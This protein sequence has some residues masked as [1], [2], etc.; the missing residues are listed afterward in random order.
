MKTV[1]KFAFSLLAA[2]VLFAVFAVFAFSGLFDVIESRF[3]NRRVTLVIEQDVLFA[4]ENEKV[5]GVL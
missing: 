4:K 2:I 5:F 1:Q 3:Y